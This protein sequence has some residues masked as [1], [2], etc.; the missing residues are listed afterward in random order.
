MR[1]ASHALRNAFAEIGAVGTAQRLHRLEYEVS[2]GD[3][4]TACEIMA[5]V[6]AELA[7]IRDHIA[8]TISS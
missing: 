1:R 6:T 3:R 7:S 5:K 8:R 2:D 4:A